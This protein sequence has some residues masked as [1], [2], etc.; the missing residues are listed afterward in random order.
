MQ[1]LWL[2][3]VLIA[4]AQAGPLC[5]GGRCDLDKGIAPL[6]PVPVDPDE[7]IAL[8]QMGSHYVKDSSGGAAALCQSPPEDQDAYNRCALEKYS[9]HFM[10]IEQACGESYMRTPLC[11][12]SF[13]TNASACAS[14]LM[15]SLPSAGDVKG[16]DCGSKFV[17]KTMEQLFQEAPRADRKDI[18]CIMLESLNLSAIMERNA[19]FCMSRNLYNIMDKD[20]N[21]SL[22]K[23]VASI[24]D[25]ARL[26]VSYRNWAKSLIRDQV[27]TKACHNEMGAEILYLRD[28]KIYG[29]RDGTTFHKLVARECTKM[30]EKERINPGGCHDFRNLS[31]HFQR[32]VLQEILAQAQVTNAEVNHICQSGSR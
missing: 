23:L 9:E 29:S 19:A 28:E 20:F 17:G 8:L 22:V 2:T 21:P 18:N 30:A 5:T 1:M 25:Q 10:D 27:M 6:Q 24:W 26:A 15:R 4:N 7:G 16:V 3:A 31:N 11:E 14:L 13:A 12:G 32:K